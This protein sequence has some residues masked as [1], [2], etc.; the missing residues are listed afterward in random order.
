[1]KKSE[2]EPQK[3]QKKNREIASCLPRKKSSLLPVFGPSDVPIL[4]ENMA[5]SSPLSR[6]DQTF[7]C[8]FPFSGFQIVP[9]VSS[10][11]SSL[12]RRARCSCN[13]FNAFI[14]FFFGLHSQISNIIHHPRVVVNQKSQNE[15]QRRRTKRS[16]S[17]SRL[18]KDGAFVRFRRA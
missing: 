4:N 6:N 11:S 9:S 17:L 16:L 13:A 12:P 14:S 7:C 18:K 2:R 1:M 10:S 3:S 15:R 5:K 8:P